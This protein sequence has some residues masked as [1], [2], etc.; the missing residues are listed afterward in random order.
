ML[1][2]LKLLIVLIPFVYQLFEV[3][4]AEVLPG[5]VLYAPATGSS[6]LLLD[7]NQDTVYMWDSLTRGNCFSVHLKDNGNI[8]R[9]TSAS[10]TSK[11]GINGANSGLIQEID[12]QG[13]VVWEFEYSTTEYCQHHNIMPMPNGNILAV[14]YEKRTAEE[15]L[16]KGIPVDTSSNPWGG[17]WPGMSSGG[18]TSLLAERF[19]EID[20]TKPQGQEI[21]W[22]WHIWDH[23]IDSTQASSNPQLFGANMGGGG[24]VANFD[25]W[26]HLNGFDYNEELD[27]IVFSSRLF[28]EIYI[29]DHSTTTQEAATHSGGR[30][31][32]GGDILYRWGKPSNY[33]APGTD[34]LN[35]VHCPNWIKRGF[36]G[37]GNIMMFS[38]RERESQS[39]VVEIIPPLK[40]D[41]TYEYSSGRAYGPEQPHWVYTDTEFK[42]ENMSSCQRLRNGNTLI[43]EAAKGRI[44]EVSPA[45]ETLWLYEPEGSG[46]GMFGGGTM[47]ARAIKYEPDHPGIKKLL[48]SSSMSNK[49]N[50]VKDKNI[51]IQY[52][53][54]KVEIDGAAGSRMSVFSI[55]GKKMVSSDIS[56]NRYRLDI[57]NLSFG[58]YIIKTS[59]KNG[60]VS[61][62]ISIVR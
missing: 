40:Q 45:K 14:A 5:Y 31:G 49:K 16:A 52:V 47:M 25:D 22:M 7:T 24:M 11:T 8:L 44:R 37:E 50:A 48:T 58:T 57:S 32:R 34:F 59:S 3:S 43:C 53:S 13:N 4:A 60:T 56:T 9:P 19:I 20:P 61:K 26:V 39:E 21:V 15:A 6:A 41:G 1:R 30:A 35:V 33:G 29:I 10:N 51:K 17:G 38:N 42:S 36:P 28:S 27:Q 2:R 54:G 46:W 12:P 62:Q 18:K 23:I 55:H